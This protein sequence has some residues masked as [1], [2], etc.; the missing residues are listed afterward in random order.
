MRRDIYQELK[1]RIVELDL[2][3]GDTLHEKG[4]SEEFSVSRTP[5]REALIR[6][7]S[8]GLVK[9]TAGRGAHVA[10]ISLRH[11][12]ESYEIRLHLAGLVGRLIVAHAT[13]S[14]L[15]ELDQMVQHIEAASDATALRRLDLTFHDLINHATHNMLLAEY[16]RRLRDR[17][18]RVWD[19]SISAGADDY[20]VRIHE[21]FSLILAAVREKK[22]EEVIDLLRAHLTRFVDEIIGFSSHVR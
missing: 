16:L 15:A 4:L 19:T 6:L 9:V 8:D 20:F 13:E 2:K 7:E 17:F 14:E 21:E 1:Q 3:P 18:S 11:L 5:I 12:K 10:E 22:S